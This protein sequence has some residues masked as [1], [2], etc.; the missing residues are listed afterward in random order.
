[1]VIL[2]AH[3]LGLGSRPLERPESWHCGEPYPWATREERVGKVF[4]LIDHEDLDE[5]TLLTV[6]ERIAVLSGPVEKATD[7]ARAR[8]GE[9]L[10]V[11]APG[12]GSGGVGDGATQSSSRSQA[13]SDE[14]RHARSITASGTTRFVGRP[15]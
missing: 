1:V 12:L 9:R 8:A 3:M 14:D 6:R 4:H 7:E 11:S 13:L 15:F 10:K 2:G 5:A